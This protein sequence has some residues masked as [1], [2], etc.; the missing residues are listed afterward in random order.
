M[1]IANAYPSPATAGIVDVARH[2]ASA[3]K[4]IEHH[5]LGG[6]MMQ[7]MPLHPFMSYLHHRLLNY[8]WLLLKN[9]RAFLPDEDHLPPPKEAIKILKWLKA[10]FYHRANSEREI[11]KQVND[12]ALGDDVG[13]IRDLT[14]R[15]VEGKERMTEREMSDVLEVNKRQAVALRAAHE[16]LK[17]PLE[18]PWELTEMVLREFKEVEDGSVKNGL[19]EVVI[20]EAYG[21]VEVEVNGVCT[22]VE[23]EIVERASS[24]SNNA[25]ERTCRPST[26][27]IHVHPPYHTS[28]RAWFANPVT[29]SDLIGSPDQYTHPP[30]ASYT[31]I[32]G[33]NNDKNGS[34]EGASH[35]IDATALGISGL[36]I[37]KLEHPLMEDAVKNLDWDVLR[38]LRLALWDYTNGHPERKGERESLEVLRGELRR[39]TA[40]AMEGPVADEIHDQDG[41]RCEKTVSSN[42]VNGDAV[43]PAPSKEPQKST[44]RD[45]YA[46]DSA[47][48]QLNGRASP[49]SASANSSRNF[50]NA[51]LDHLFE[52]AQPLP[53]STSHQNGNIDQN[54]PLLQSHPYENPNNHI[55]DHPPTTQSPSYLMSMSG[56]Y[57]PVTPLFLE[58]EEDSTPI[59]LPAAKSPTIPRLPRPP[60]TPNSASN[61]KPC[62][63]TRMKQKLRSSRRQSPTTTST[64]PPLAPLTRQPTPPLTPLTPPTSPCPTP[65]T[66]S[67]SDPWLAPLN[68]SYAYNPYPSPKKKLRSSRGRGRIE[69][70]TAASNS[71]EETTSSKK[72]FDFGFYF[73]VDERV[74]VEIIDG[75]RVGEI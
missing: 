65:S 12:R 67:S 26:P 10:F 28:G 11:L 32:S 20:K 64:P 59:D 51:S 19:D 30:P 2:I 43:S 5:Y 7:T 13:F 40:Q 66:L 8:E 27:K 62:C 39:R 50:S 4:F 52:S 58:Q 41:R 29:F 48:A 56:A 57:N 69:E 18:R 72:G 35:F 46:S 63:F 38:F 23:D 6:L 74:P 21:D 60:S 44:P 24:S 16:A 75:M 45:L 68:T 36:T 71:I 25:L 42:D 1:D 55:H 53:E 73:D 54:T 17:E 34:D 49:P 31:L 33:T 61:D 15:L 70:T 14:E 9:K 22:P 3:A 47:G 37:L